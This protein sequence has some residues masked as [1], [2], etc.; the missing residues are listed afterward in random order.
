MGDA[1][2]TNKARATEDWLLREITNRT[3]GA[4]SVRILDDAAKKV[5]LMCMKTAKGELTRN[6]LTDRR[7]SQ[8]FPQTRLLRLYRTHPKPNHKNPKQNPSTLL[9]FKLVYLTPG[10]PLS[11]LDG[12]VACDGLDGSF[13]SRNYTTNASPP[14]CPR[15]PPIR[16]PRAP[17][18]PE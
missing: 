9:P 15:P 12:L 16:L 18:H 11:S 14:P 17:L 4:L 2:F 8:K 6:P 10:P 5:S 1:Y 3:F 13:F 7:A